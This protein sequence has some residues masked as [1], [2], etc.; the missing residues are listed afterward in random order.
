MFPAKAGAT[1]SPWKSSQEHGQP[2]TWPHR[3]RR[4][5]IGRTALGGEGW[6]SFSTIAGADGRQQ[7]MHPDCSHKKTGSSFTG[8][9]PFFYGRDGAI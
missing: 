2:A 5:R 6:P 7:G 8:T 3:L 1:I 9:R 4:A